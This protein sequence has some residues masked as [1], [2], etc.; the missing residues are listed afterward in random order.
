MANTIARIAEREAKARLRDNR[1]WNDCEFAY[2]PSTGAVGC[3]WNDETETSESFHLQ[4]RIF[5]VNYPMYGRGDDV[6][7]WVSVGRGINRG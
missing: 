3:R 6:H 4:Y 2:S 1:R 5:N 7:D